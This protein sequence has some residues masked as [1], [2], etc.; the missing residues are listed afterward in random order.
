MSA[1]SKFE[2]LVVK[3]H[4]IMPLGIA[5]IIDAQSDMKVCG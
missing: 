3:D 1:P 2:V 4:P 5:A